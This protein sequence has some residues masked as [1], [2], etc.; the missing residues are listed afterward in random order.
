M[1]VNWKVRFKNGPFLVGFFSLIISFAYA[2]LELFDVFPSLQ[3]STVMD[4][5]MKVLYVLG[6]MGVITDPTTAGLGDSKR[7]LS[8]EKPWVDEEGEP[9]D[10]T[11]EE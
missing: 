11:E 2:M 8:Y 1:K 3:E 4:I 7:A 5:I 9:F 6:L 10:Q